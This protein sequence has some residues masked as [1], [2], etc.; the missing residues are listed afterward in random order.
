MDIICTRTSNGIPQINITP[1]LHHHSPDGFEFG[2]G[3]SGPADLALNI[4]DM[5][6]GDNGESRVTLWDKNTTSQS[7]W[8]LHQDFKNHFIASMNKDG[9]TIKGQDVLNW[10]KERNHI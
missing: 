2:Y 3:G 6:I 9:G 10:I 4:L 5:F 7:A 8:N 1:H